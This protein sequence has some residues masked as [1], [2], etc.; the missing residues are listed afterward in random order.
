M[1]SN[2]NYFDVLDVR[3]DASAEDILRAYLA[4]AHQYHPDSQHSTNKKQ[5]VT[6]DELMKGINQASEVLRDSEKRGRY[7]RPLSCGQQE[8][9]TPGTS[10]CVM[11]TVH[12]AN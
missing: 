8:A 12:S 5:L 2:P 4:K 9:P 11:W 3:I 6:S 1:P 10:L 7:K